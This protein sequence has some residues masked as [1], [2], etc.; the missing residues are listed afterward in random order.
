M[1]M[2]TLSHV[3]AI[4]V[5]ALQTSCADSRRTPPG[6]TGD[7]SELCGTWRSL[8]S[9]R[10]MVFDSDGDLLFLDSRTNQPS[11]EP[12]GK[13]RRLDDKR[14]ELVRNTG[15]GQMTKVALVSFDGHDLILRRE[16]DPTLAERHERIWGKSTIG[17]RP[18][19]D[20]LNSISGS[21]TPSVTNGP[22]HER[23][24]AVLADARRL[25]FQDRDLAR[26]R[27]AAEK[28]LGQDATLV[29]AYSLINMCMLGTSA[30]NADRIALLRKGL[31]HCPESGHLWFLLGHA[32]ASA[33][34]REEALRSYAEALQLDLLELDSVHYNMGNVY[35]D[36]EDL[37]AAKRHYENCLFINPDHLKAIHQ[38]VGTCAMFGDIESAKAYANTLIK[39]DPGGKEEAF[40]RKALE[41]IEN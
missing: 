37:R 7:A 11:A 15:A 32:Y 30:S 20:T 38:L 22:G 26:G 1:R 10:V 24:N 12:V 35:Y 6:P 17:Y 19:M 27:A 39:K 34:Q 9:D 3:I 18:T 21:A 25:I 5:V 13:W 28:A 23:D 29:E 31:T 33:Q 16:E 2:K 8:Q 41:M 40:A 14:V 36:M 4:L